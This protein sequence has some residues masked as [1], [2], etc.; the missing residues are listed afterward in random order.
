M[1]NPP[2]W[3]DYSAETDDDKAGV[4]TQIRHWW[5]GGEKYLCVNKKLNSFRF[6]AE[7]K[8]TMSEV[9]PCYL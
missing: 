2:M 1:I 8:G 5:E 9:L 4:S 3:S 7:L 6:R